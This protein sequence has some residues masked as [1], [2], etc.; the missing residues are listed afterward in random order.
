MKFI[1]VAL[2]G[3]LGAIA[4]YAISLIPVRMTFPVLTLVTNIAGAILIGFIVG[5]ADRKGDVSANA[6]LFWKT[7]VCGGFTTFSTF[8][9]E[10]CNL[11]EKRIYIAGGIYVALSVGCCV[12][13]IL[14]GK[15]LS[16]L[17]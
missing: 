16:Y 14:I 9:L 12:L 1:F 7:G 13:G 3:A 2:G 11:F 6:V 15:K 8:S 4:R 10:S 5:I 17:I